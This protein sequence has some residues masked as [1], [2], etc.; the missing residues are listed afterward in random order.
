LVR[1][2]PSKVTISVQEVEETITIKSEED[3]ASSEDD[4]TK[5]KKEYE[6][7]MGKSNIATT[8]AVP[9][10]GPLEASEVSDED[11]DSDYEKLKL[12][13]Q[14]KIQQSSVQLTVAASAHALYDEEYEKLKAEY[15]ASTILRPA[16]DTPE[17]DDYA[18]SVASVM[19]TLEDESKS[20]KKAPMSPTS[21]LS[22]H[23]KPRP[24]VRPGSQSEQTRDPFA[25]RASASRGT[26]TNSPKR[27][28]QESLTT[29]V[30]LPQTN[31][32]NVI[33]LS[34][35]P[36]TGVTLVN[37]PDQSS[38][39]LLEQLKALAADKTNMPTFGNSLTVAVTNAHQGSHEV[40]F[41]VNIKTDMRQFGHL[42]FDQLDIWRSY[43]DFEDLQKK[44]SSSFPGFPKMPK[45]KL[46]VAAE[47]PLNEMLN[48]IASDPMMNSLTVFV[49]FFDNSKYNEEKASVNPLKGLFNTINKIKPS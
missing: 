47:A 6:K 2:N 25:N 24:A 36:I 21:R 33:Q 14:K 35:P 32:H 22:S 3:S 48:Y 43:N 17:L 9:V 15:E 31:S 44:L 46:G 38:Q 19:S 28:T 5:M 11:G 41:Q 16:V 10:A 49:D 34:C 7:L 12:E 30:S 45:K 13:Y 40:L 1:S 26:I 29:D 37:N 8:V 18:K 4:Y 20:T 42:L 27:D 39:A 23:H